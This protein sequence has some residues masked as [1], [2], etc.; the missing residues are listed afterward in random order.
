MPL[1]SF[2]WN[3]VDCSSIKNE[4][5]INHTHY[6]PQNCWTSSSSQVRA[7]AIDIN[8]GQEYVWFDIQKI[9]SGNTIWGNDYAYQNIKKDKIEDIIYNLNLGSNPNVESKSGNIKSSNN[10]IRYYYRAFE[11]SDGKGMFGGNT[12]NK[13]F[14]TFGFFTENKSANLDEE[15]MS[16]ILSSLIIPGV[17]KGQQSSIRLSG[18]STSEPSFQEVLDAVVE[19]GTGKYGEDVTIT[20]PNSSD[21]ENNNSYTGNRT[22]MLNWESVGVMQG[23]LSFNEQQRT[24]RIDFILPNDN[25]NCFGTYALSETNGTWSFLCSNDSSATGS[26][27]WNTNDNSIVGNGKDN[28]N[29]SVQI[30]VAGS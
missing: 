3:E 30:M 8:D 27:Q 21:D 26:L 29:N 19:Q 23:K 5:D 18:S 11:T 28:K 14:Y 15:F 10:K 12:I 20:I 13:L 4:I 22:F 24:G 6:S 1:I 25:S 9:I 7:L 16:E 17:N 2:A